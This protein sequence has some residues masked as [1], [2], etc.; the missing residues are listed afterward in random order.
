MD[1]E[2]VPICLNNLIVIGCPLA[3]Q[4]T[5]FLEILQT[6]LS[7]AILETRQDCLKSYI[8]TVPRRHILQAFHQ[9]QFGRYNVPTGTVELIFRFRKQ[10]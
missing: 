7:A 6:S 4:D 5:G 3:V 1:V 2:N 9:K 8:P 10:S